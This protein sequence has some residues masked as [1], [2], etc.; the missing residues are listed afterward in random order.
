LKLKLPRENPSPTHYANR[1]Y[2][3]AKLL[4]LY[5]I[6]FSL[7]TWKREFANLYY[8]GF[9]IIF[10]IEFLQILASNIAQPKYKAV[11]RSMV[12]VLLEV[13]TPLSTTTNVSNQTLMFIYQKLK[14]NNE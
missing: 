12:R 7:T 11:D 2:G 10:R 6:F 14:M 13:A 8:K 3:G 5:S 9:T 1:T 4:G